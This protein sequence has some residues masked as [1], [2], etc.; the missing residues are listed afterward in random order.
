MFH[1]FVTSLIA[2]SNEQYPLSNFKYIVYLGFVVDKTIIDCLFELQSIGGSPS[3][4][5]MQNI[6]ITVS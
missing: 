1:T 2:F 3:L 6:D 4:Y 5:N